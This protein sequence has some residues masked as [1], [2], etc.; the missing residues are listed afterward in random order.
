M[1]HSSSTPPYL[2]HALGLAMRALM[3]VVKDAFADEASVAIRVAPVGAAS[4]LAKVRPV[5]FGTK[6]RRR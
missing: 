1:K 6:G 3:A 5:P 2:Q 4:E